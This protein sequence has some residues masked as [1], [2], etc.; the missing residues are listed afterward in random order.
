VIQ[1]TAVFG[2][3]RL[4]VEWTLGA[5]ALVP[6]TYWWL[7]V[8]E[9]SAARLALSAAGFVLILA[10]WLVLLWRSRRTLCRSR[11]G[12]PGIAARLGAALLFAGSFVA[13]FKLIWWVPVIH[14]LPG[15]A[16]SM[17]VRFAAAYAVALIAGLNLIAACRG[18]LAPAGSA[19]RSSAA[20]P[21]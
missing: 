3:P 15:Q 6:L 10:I 19:P 17:A 21:G 18:L 2:N 1:L 12:A 8:N 5:A 14:S 20:T 9:T 16:L 11:E 13:A 7:G 4:L